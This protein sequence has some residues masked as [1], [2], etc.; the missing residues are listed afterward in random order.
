MKRVFSVAISLAIIVGMLFINQD[1]LAGSYEEDFVSIRLTSPINAKDTIRLYSEDGFKIYEKDDISDEIEIL[2]IEQIEVTIGE[3][4][5]EIDILDMEGEILLTFNNDEDLLIS[6]NDKDDNDKK[7][8]VEDKYYRDYVT[9]KMVEDELMTINYVKLEHYLYGVVPKEMGYSFELEALKSQSIA[10]RT[11]TVKNIN[12]H[13]NHGYDLCDTTCCQVYGGMDVEN[14]KTNRAVDE[15]S[16]MIITYNGNPIDAVYHSSSGGYTDNVGEVWGSDIPYLVAVRDEFSDG[17]P[18]ANWNL[19]MTND[20]ISARL[21]SRGMDIGEVVNIEILDT[22]TN[23]RVSQLKIEGT[24]GEEILS[25]NE[26]REILGTTELK[27]TLFTIKKDN[28]YGD[29]EKVYAIDGNSSTAKSV[30][31]NDVHIIDG[32]LN[33]GSSRGFTSRFINRNGIVEFNSDI[34]PI[35]SNFVIEGK[36]YGHGLGMS[37]WGAQGMAVEGY[38]YKDILNHYYKNVK[39][40]TIN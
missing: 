38:S 16:G 12:K 39:I 10:A 2:K 7:V 30:D 33:R 31:L 11:Y 18:N 3:E 27:S 34:K 4:D 19:A 40:D 24:E 35:E 15:T 5:D 26:F 32:N 20:E 13:D 1:V 21:H 29:K 6:S 23:G 22:T 17:Y 25:G 28:V 8:R 14:I 37:Q 36:G 9:F